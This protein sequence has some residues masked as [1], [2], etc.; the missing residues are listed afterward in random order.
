MRQRPARFFLAAA[1]LA[2]IACGGT[3]DVTDDDLTG[4]CTSFSVPGVSEKLFRTAS[5]TVYYVPSRWA[6]RRLAV[7][8]PVDGSTAPQDLAGGSPYFGRVVATVDTYPA[9]SVSD[10]QLLA[11]VR[12]K[13]P[14]T[15][16]VSAL[17]V[18][19]SGATL[20]VKAAA[21][22]GANA[23]LQPRVSQDV[24]FVVKAGVQTGASLREGVR[25]LSVNGTLKPTA[26][27]IPSFALSSSAPNVPFPQNTVATDEAQVVTNAAWMVEN[28]KALS[29]Y[30]NANYHATFPQ[31][32]YSQ[33]LA[34][35][36]PIETELAAYA[37]YNAAWPLSRV[38]ALGTKA[39]NA[40]SAF[41]KAVFAAFS[42]T[43]PSDLRA[44]FKNQ[45]RGTWLTPFDAQA[46]GPVFTHAMAL[47]TYVIGEALHPIR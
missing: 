36:R 29:S 24:R 26:C 42:V 45:A 27:N 18:T 47:E 21:G 40:V 25:A 35:L 34:D 31:A 15:S 11:A 19:V 1:A 44:Y 30:W 14:A 17:P 39:V 12:A 4:A 22:E 43:A 28:A 20:Q 16:K 3:D 5:G 38:H 7:A 41:A 9:A 23:T 32:A 2:A 13:Y 10:A 8:T 46:V 37:S 33:L 6:V